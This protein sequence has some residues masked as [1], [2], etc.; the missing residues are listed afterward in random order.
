MLVEEAAARP[1]VAAGCGREGGAGLALAAMAMVRSLAMSR[2]RPGWPCGV[3]C[4]EVS[5][6]KR[7]RPAGAALSGW[8]R[9]VAGARSP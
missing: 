5:E 6:A 8:L 7:V 1:V 4:C 9:G 2:A 3:E